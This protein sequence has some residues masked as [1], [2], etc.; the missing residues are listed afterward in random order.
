MVVLTAGN[1]RKASYSLQY[2]ANGKWNPLEVKNEGGKK[3]SIY[4]FER[5]WCEKIKV[6]ISDFDS[7][8]AISE[9]GVFNERR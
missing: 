2:Y 4:R 5:I 8:P 9:L 1:N 6:T 3:V 7:A